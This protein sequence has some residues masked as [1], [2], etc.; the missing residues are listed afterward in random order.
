MMYPTLSQPYLLPELVHRQTPH[1]LMRFPPSSK[2]S[3][4]QHSLHIVALF[5]IHGIS[6]D[7][8]RISLWSCG[9]L[10]SLH[11]CH[12]MPSC[13]VWEQLPNEWWVPYNIFAITYLTE[14]L[15]IHRLINA[16]M[17]GAANLLGLQRRMLESG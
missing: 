16:S 11:H 10:C 5:S 8:L 6:H 4:F 12:M 7:P 13:T 17:I 3:S 2:K 14:V 1:Y 15:M 9:L